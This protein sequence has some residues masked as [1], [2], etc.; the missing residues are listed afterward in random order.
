M[1]MGN[2]AHESKLSIVDLERLILRRQRALT[3]LLR[4]RQQTERKLATLNERI[5]ELGGTDATNVRM[6]RARNSM[7]LPA[8]I[9]KVLSGAKQAMKVGEIVRDVQLTGYRSTSKNFRGIV[10]QTLIKDPQFAAV[11]R[12]SYNIR[13]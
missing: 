8:A 1:A 12:G 5:A 7:T 2:M 3:R 6:K 10:N 11:S 4:Q 13:H 9:A